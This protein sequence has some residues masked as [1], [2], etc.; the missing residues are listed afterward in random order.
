M[1]QISEAFVDKLYENVATHNKHFDKAQS[2]TTIIEIKQNNPNLRNYHSSMYL[3]TKMMLSHYIKSRSGKEFGYDQ[4]DCD[5]IK[6]HIEQSYMTDKQQI[7]LYD[8]TAVGLKAIG[9]DS[10]WIRD[11]VLNIKLRVF[12][13]DNWVKYLIVLSGKSKLNCI[14]TLLLLFCIECIFL[15]PV[16]DKDHAL[17]A[18]KVENYCDNPFF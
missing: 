2:L 12:K 8:K 14:C 9:E 17:F 10:E 3:D 5:F 18:M 11:R 7:S 15:L 13:R 4:L 6:D 16:A 1:I